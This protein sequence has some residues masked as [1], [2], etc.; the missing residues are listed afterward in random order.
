VASVTTLFPPLGNLGDFPLH[1]RQL[2]GPPERDTARAMSEENVEIVRQT[3]AVRAH[4]RRR[5]EER[6]GLR[7]PRAL[8]FLAGAVWRLPP[9]SWVR[10]AMIRRAVRLGVEATNRGDYEASF[11]L[12]HRDCE[13]IFASQL[14]TVGEPGTRGREERI[15]WQRRWSADWG[16]FRI[17]PEELIDLGG[18]QL[19]IGRMKGSGLSS[20]APVDNDYGQLW[21]ISAGRVIREQIF[22]DHGEAL[23][24]AGLS[25]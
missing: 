23:E 17:E 3:I 6:L 8:A 4:S 9:R 21:T 16:E 12:Y 1:R 10:Q 25:E 15:R 19:V 11:F 5:V 22:M 7:F 18:R 2:R 20:G 24:A 14:A 13:T